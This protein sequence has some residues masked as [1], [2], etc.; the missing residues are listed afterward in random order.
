MTM[1]TASTIRRRPA[2]ASLLCA[3]A[4]LSAP[5]TGFAGAKP[6]E[7]RGGSITY[8]HLPG[9][10]TNIMRANGR[11]GVVTIEAGLDIQDAA[12]RLRVQ[13][14]VPLL[15]DGYTRALAGIGPS[16]HPGSQP[17]L[18]RVATSLQSVTDRI[19][20]KPGAVFLVGSVI[21]N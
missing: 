19:L 20:G 13:H 4:A 16:V 11:W 15:M 17:D 9:L 3:I 14:S 5:S 7:H 18:D 8:V 10:T 1:Q 21:V 12:L 2:L 6:A